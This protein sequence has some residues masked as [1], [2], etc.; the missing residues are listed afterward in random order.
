M[1]SFGFL[2]VPNEA[3]INL[4]GCHFVF[5]GS[6]LAGIV[7][8]GAFVPRDEVIIHHGLVAHLYLMPF[9]RHAVVIRIAYQIGHII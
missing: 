9:L 1:S 3:A 8:I 7:G 5:G 2:E 6:Y 4:S